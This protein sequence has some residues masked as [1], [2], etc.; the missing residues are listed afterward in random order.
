MTNL[1]SF[2][3]GVCGGVLLKVATKQMEKW[4]TL[5]KIKLNW[6]N[7]SFANAFAGIQ[8]FLI[9]LSAENGS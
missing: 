9:F 8:A 1:M 5:F 6:Q 2:S 3:L 7:I 4:S